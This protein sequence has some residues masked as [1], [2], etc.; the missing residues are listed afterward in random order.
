M[1]NASLR[2]KAT[3]DLVKVDETGV[4][5]PSYRNITLTDVTDYA[6]LGVSLSS[7]SGYFVI[8]DPVGNILYQ[9]DFTTPDIVHSVSTSFNGVQI[10]LDA[11]NKPLSGTYKFQMFIRR[12]VGSSTVNFNTTELPFSFCM[13]GCKSCTKPNIEMLFD[14]NVA[15][16]TGYDKTAYKSNA[17][18]ERRLTLVPPVGAKF[19]DGTDALTLV[20]PTNQVSSNAL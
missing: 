4:A 14:C 3:L 11:Y 12:V 1:N 17:S 2:L 19:L 10:P 7:L 6:S 16:A 15:T 18:V 8:K 5:N 9:G 13:D 20:S